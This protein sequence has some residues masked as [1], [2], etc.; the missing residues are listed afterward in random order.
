MKFYKLAI[1]IIIAALVL[2]CTNNSSNKKDGYSTITGVFDIPYKNEVTLS[3]VE[4]G[5]SFVIATSVVN[6]NKEFG[7]NVKPEKE[8]FYLIGDKDI[9]VPMYLK[10]NQT[11]N[12]TYNA[13]GYQLL[14]T[15]DN[16]NEIL[17][18]WIQ[19]M[20]TL[21]VFDFR[22][23]SGKTYKDFFPFYEKYIPELK[24][25]HDNVNS[26]N[27]HFNK[28]MHAYID[29]KIEKEALSFLFTPRSEHPKK[30]QMAPF[31]TE[32][33]KGENFYTDIALNLPDGINTLRLHEMY[34]TSYVAKVGRDKAINYMIN[35]TKNDKLRGYLALEYL[36][37]FKSYNEN[38]LKFIEPLRKDIA[39]SPYVTAEVDKFE[40][41][42]KTMGP[43]TQGYPFTYKNENGKEVSFSDFKGKLVYIDVW[44][45]WCSPCKKQIPFIKQLEKDLHGKDI[46]FVSISM[47][48]Q[49]DHGK[50]KQFL[51]DEKLTGVQ[52]F[53][54]DAF[55]TR[56][57]KDYKIN[58]IPRFLLFDKEGKIVDANA[59]RPSD[60]ALKKQL[61]KLLK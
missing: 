22:K 19:K 2:S 39:L 42:I 38:Y 25:E 55:N 37:G 52:L 54:D 40:V 21:K 29:L 56:I 50:W 47:D 17:H 43:G 30:N 53:S 10:G 46:Q 61:L 60:P 4:H 35:N 14:N 51:K 9:N 3:K 57:A 34:N 59:K 32:F 49:K 45:T 1:A 26:S 5:K 41:G 15:P 48:K 12:I 16:E 44:A 31:Y 13:D 28:L 20:D 24:K 23:G 36:R 8:G 33:M 27:E 18:K 7:F 58:A 6:A 11:F